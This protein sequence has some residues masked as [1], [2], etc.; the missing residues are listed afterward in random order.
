ME[1]ELKNNNKKCMALHSEVLKEF[2]TDTVEILSQYL[3]Y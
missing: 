3:F 2:Q 1:F